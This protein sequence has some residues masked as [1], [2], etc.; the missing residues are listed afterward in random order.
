[1][2]DVDPFVDF[3]FYPEPS[4]VGVVAEVVVFA[5]VHFL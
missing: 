2:L 3:F 4:A 1:M 5:V